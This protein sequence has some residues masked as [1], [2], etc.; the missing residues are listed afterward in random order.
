MADNI[1]PTISSIT[2]PSGNTYYIKDATARAA[3]AALE[4]G[5]YFLGVT[6][7]PLYDQA[8]TSP[9]TLTKIDPETNQ[10]MVA[11][12]QNGQI[13][14]YG[15]KEFIFD[16]TNWNEF[17]DLTN[18]GALAYLDQIDTTTDSVL[19]ADTT[20]SV[21]TASVTFSGRTTDVVLGE[22]TTFSATGAN[23]A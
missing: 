10:P 20:F 5:S 16:G 15:H 3:I 9:I 8:T 21:N 1:Q 4:G 11:T 14:I 12:P 17:G 2:L 23:T 7:T 6:T 18:M 19:G 22:G 13:A